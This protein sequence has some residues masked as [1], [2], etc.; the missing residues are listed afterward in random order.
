MNFTEEYTEVR[1]KKYKTVIIAVA[2]VAFCGLAL[3]I[4]L[5]SNSRDEGTNI[6][7]QNDHVGQSDLTIL[8][9]DSTIVQLK[10]PAP[11]VNRRR[12]SVVTVP[13]QGR[14][15]GRTLTSRKGR[16]YSVFYKI[17][18]AQPP[19]GN[20]RFQPPQTPKRW[21]G[22]RDA[23]KPGPQCIQRE[24]YAPEPI[25]AGEE[26]CLFL[27]IYTTALPKTEGD[28]PSLPVLFYLHGGASNGNG[29]RYGGK[30]FMDED[31]VLVTIEFRVGILGYLRTDTIDYPGNYG[32]KDQVFAL[33]WVQQNIQ[34]FGG[35]PKRV[36]IFGNSGGGQAVHALLVSP[37]SEG[38]FSTAILQSGNCLR[39]VP[40]SL[41]LTQ[42]LGREVG[43][44]SSKNEEFVECL[45]K[46][47]AK[48]LVL[49]FSQN[50]EIGPFKEMV[51]ENG[52]ESNTFLPDFT[53]N[54]IQQGRSHRV[55][56]IFG[57]V[58]EEALG[59]TS[60][61]YLL[62]ENSTRVL[63]TNW[64][65][66]FPSIVQIPDNE[67]HSVATK[68]RDVYFGDKYV[69]NDTRLELLHMGSDAYV[70]SQRVAALLQAQTTDQPVYLYW[71]TKEPAKSYAEQYKQRFP[72][73][74]GVAH[75]DELQYLFLYDGYPEIT[76]DSPWFKYSEALVKIWVSFATT[77]KPASPSEDWKPIDLAD[78]GMK[79]FEL[80]D[81][82]REVEPVTERMLLWDEYTDKLYVPAT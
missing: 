40:D 62:T 78:N 18:Y 12:N 14:L 64:D 39:Q 10:A 28:N 1:V 42:L 20:L 27:N 16:D 60:S 31:V 50:L 58:S 57:D 68:F 82:F 21:R 72:P 6:L 52:D 71:I 49:T 25:S 75:A 23:T 32:S 4:V 11:S 67:N 24:K 26:D 59:S 35:D 56:T 3:G 29:T 55:P 8:G 22:V 7:T 34:R 45:R 13:R 76:V 17:P 66:L 9:E 30:Y 65:D 80:G 44:D 48:K 54:L 19:L 33:K 37:M 47:E 79:W 43:C 36:M 2:T 69:N 73:P 74:Y 41:P 63:N 61:D 5:G 81:Q 15:R 77:G 53:W 51:P 70:H 38:L 46:V